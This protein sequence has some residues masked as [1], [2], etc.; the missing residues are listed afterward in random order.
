MR[1]TFTLQHPLLQCSLQRAPSTRVVW[2]ESD[3][4]D[5]GEL[6]LLFWAESEDYEAFE[7]AMG[8]DSTVTA[9]RRLAEFRD[10]RLYQVEVIGEAR[11]RQVYPT[12]VEVG[13]IIEACTGTDQGWKLDVTFPDQEALQHFHDVCSEYDLD[14]RLVQK[15]EQSNGPD[16]TADF[17]LTEKQRHALALASELGYFEVPRG[18][19]LTTVGEELGISHQAASERVRR[20]V[21]VL[22]RRTIGAE[23]DTQPQ[24]AD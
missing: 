11:V 22:V 7:T 6:L 21:D 4:T 3:R 8:D 10:R 17:G 14:F 19:D 16:A 23:A 20:A 18:A 5:N 24:E 13:G 1:A 9:P 12:L 15:Y 2:E